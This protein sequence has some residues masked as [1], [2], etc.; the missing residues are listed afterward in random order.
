MIKEIVDGVIEM[1]L[2]FRLAKINPELLLKRVKREDV[3]SNFISKVHSKITDMR[4]KF[5]LVN[6]TY[7][8]CSPSE[9]DYH[10]R[11][12]I[13]GLAEQEELKQRVKMFK[14]VWRELPQFRKSEHVK[15]K[16]NK[17]EQQNVKSD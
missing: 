16:I 5:D 14:E 7:N 11:M 6:Q 13:E 8:L 9:W 12:G 1:G 10:E 2:A 3:K 4:G 15:K 17:K